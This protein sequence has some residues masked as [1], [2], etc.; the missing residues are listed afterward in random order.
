L[1]FNGIRQVTQV[2]RHLRKRDIHFNFALE[3]FHTGPSPGRRQHRSA[4]FVKVSVAA[5][6]SYLVV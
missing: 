2:R 4:G 5:L 1:A 3:V 6:I